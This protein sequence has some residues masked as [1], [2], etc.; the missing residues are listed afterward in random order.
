MWITENNNIL[1]RVAILA[2]RS[3]RQLKDFADQALGIPTN[4]TIGPLNV[5]TNG[6]NIVK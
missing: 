3:I 4:K 1:L 5:S 6:L 2:L